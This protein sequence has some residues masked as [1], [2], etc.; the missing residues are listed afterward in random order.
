MGSDYT[1]RIVTAN[2]TTLLLRWREGDRTAQEQLMP[3]VYQHLRQLAHAYIARESGGQ[4]LD[5][6]GVV[7]EVFLRLTQQAEAGWTDRAHFF[8]FAARL[9][10][11]ILVDEARAR[12]AGKRGGGRARV[13][14]SSDMAWVDA[15]SE[16]M[17]DLDRALE[18][19]A[20]AFPDAVVILE[21]R[22]FLGCTS[23]ETAA[24]LGVSKP[25]VDRRFALA[26]AWLYDR[27]HR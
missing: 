1:G 23:E 15:S 2:V 20:K 18:E 3:L 25:T 5:A 22:V 12:N 14:L 9:M 8:G 4:I 7:H 26:K 24:L 17:L 6:T 10:R 16:E 13:P 11:Q 19:L 27:L 21:H